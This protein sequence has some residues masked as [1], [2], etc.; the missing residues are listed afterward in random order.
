MTSSACAGQLPRA[1][2]AR[3]LLLRPNQ[4]RAAE[5]TERA[6]RLIVA[7]KYAKVAV[8]LI[9]SVLLAA[10]TA[11]GGIPAL[12]RVAAQLRHHVTSAWSVEL[13]DALVR[14]LVPRHLWMVAAALALDGTLTFVE[15]R[16]LQRGWWWGPW[17]VVVA[18]CGLLP[19][20]VLALVR[21]AALGRVALLAANVGVALYLARHALRRHPRAAVP[22]A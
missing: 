9:A 7:Y 4:M 18:T 8:E 11:T 12:G 10:L 21:H 22:Q 5:P 2:R 1:P 3:R 20:E 6:I 17:L 19:F 14:E 16:S 15:G 13:A